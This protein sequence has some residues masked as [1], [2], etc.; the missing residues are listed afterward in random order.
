MAADLAT[1]GA[2]T[3][4][5]VIANTSN[6]YIDRGY[7]MGS[8]KCAL[9]K[10][11]DIIWWSEEDGWGHLYRYSPTGELVARLT[12][13]PWHVDGFTGFD[14][15]ESTVFLEGCGRE[16]AEDPYYKHVYSAP[17]SGG[18]VTLL[19]VGNGDHTG[20][21]LCE[22]GAYFVENTSRVDTVPAVTLRNAKVRPQEIYQSPACI[23]S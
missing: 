1:G 16:A 20:V 7:D 14:K 4:R 6:T 3:I 18:E 2:I 8:G 17:L 5:T 9:M 19:D 11:G 12:A 22:S 13:G 15:D 10:S 21:S 23:Y